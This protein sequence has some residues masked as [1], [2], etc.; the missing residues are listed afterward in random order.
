[1]HNT[2]ILLTTLIVFADQRICFPFI[3]K[4]IFVLSTITITTKPKEV[5]WEH[6]H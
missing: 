5:I 2:V 3:A 1:M 6:K 4:S